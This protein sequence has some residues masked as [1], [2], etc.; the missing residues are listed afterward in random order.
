MGIQ[1]NHSENE[2][3]LKYV[4][5]KCESVDTN[6]VSSFG[7]AQVGVIAHVCSCKIIS[8]WAKTAC[9]VKF[10]FSKFI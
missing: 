5:L 9:V 6:Y 3:I 4:F 1:I 7:F 2:Y 10:S 8:A